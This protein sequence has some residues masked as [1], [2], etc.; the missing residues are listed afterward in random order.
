MSDK[1]EEMSFESLKAERES[2]LKTLREVDSRV[3]SRGLLKSSCQPYGGELSGKNEEEL[4]RLDRLIEAEIAKHQTKR[5][6][7]TNTPGCS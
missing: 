5:A 4:Q 3:V 6:S 2:F 1:K 7:G